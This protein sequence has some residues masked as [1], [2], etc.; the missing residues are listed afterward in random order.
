MSIVGVVL[1]AVQFAFFAVAWWLPITR[2]IVA[3]WEFAL[4]GALTV[5]WALLSPATYLLFA[6][7]LSAG[8]IARARL[9]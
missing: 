2:P 8:A 6:A 3:T 4:A 7:V 5:A 1:A 9:P